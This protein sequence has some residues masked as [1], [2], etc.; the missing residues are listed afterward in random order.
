MHDPDLDR[1]VTIRHPHATAPALGHPIHSLLA[2]FPI[3]YFCGAF[4]TD[5]V[6]SRTAYL[7]WQ[8]FSIWLITAGLVFGALAAVAGIVDHFAGRRARHR[9]AGSHTILTSLAWLLSLLNAFV[10]SRDG[11]IAVVPQGLILSGI[12]TVLM[13]V[14]AWL[15]YRYDAPVLRADER[16]VVR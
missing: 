3:A 9:H 16:E 5:I 13:L 6:Y 10:H 1:T 2:A 14:G 15:G 7:M 8:Y 12:V 4:V 11:W